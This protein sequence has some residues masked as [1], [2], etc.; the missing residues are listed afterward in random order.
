MEKQVFIRC[1]ERDAKL[2]EGLLESAS[3]EFT[4][5][6]KK[7]TGVEFITKVEI[8]RNNVLSEHDCEYYY[9]QHV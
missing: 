1:K 9:L 4:E 7:E 6:I 3:K 5:L 8:D 2:V